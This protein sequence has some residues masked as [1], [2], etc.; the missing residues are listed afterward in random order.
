[1]KRFAYS[2]EYPEDAE[3]AGREGTVRVSFIVDTAG[4]VERAAVI[5]SVG[6]QCDKE[7]LRAVQRARFTPGRYQ[8]N[9][10]NVKMCIAVHY[11]LPEATVHASLCPA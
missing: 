2:F 11:E 7:A 5:Q 9:L 10:V 3:E 4:V 1:M 6:E 8:G